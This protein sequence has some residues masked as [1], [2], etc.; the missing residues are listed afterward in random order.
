MVVCKLIIITLKLQLNRKVYIVLLILSIKMTLSESIRNVVDQFK[1]KYGNDQFKYGNLTQVTGFPKGPHYHVAGPVDGSDDILLRKH[2][3][4]DLVVDPLFI[5][6]DEQ[7]SV[8]RV[9]QSGRAIS[10]EDRA[11]LAESFRAIGK[12]YLKGRFDIGEVTPLNNDVFM[13]PLDR[14]EVNRVLSALENLED[15]TITGSIEKRP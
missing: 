5:S 11:K 10:D 1:Y 12:A 15:L 7:I 13:L 6:D 9:L 4:R 8:I 2:D 14:Q 3:V